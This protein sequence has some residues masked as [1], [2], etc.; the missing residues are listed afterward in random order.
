MGRPPRQTPAEICRIVA[1]HPEP[2]VSVADVYEDMK[3]TKRGAQER[4]KTLV[5]EGFLDSKKVGHAGLVFW[6]TDD[7]KQA[8]DDAR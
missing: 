3:M 2:V 5:D 4:L 1:L 6:L 7:G 8:L